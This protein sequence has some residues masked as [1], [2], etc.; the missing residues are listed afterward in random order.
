MSRTILSLGKSLTFFTVC[1]LCKI[2]RRGVGDRDGEE[3]RHVEEDGD[4]SVHY[5][6]ALEE[7]GLL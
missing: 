1:R 5:I 3:D 6:G 2:E 7:K 4:D